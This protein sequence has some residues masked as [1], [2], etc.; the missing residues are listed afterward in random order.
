MRNIRHDRLLCVLQPS[1]IRSFFFRKHD[2][3][4]TDAQTTCQNKGKSENPYP[5]RMLMHYMLHRTGIITH[6]LLIYKCKYTVTGHTS[7]ASELHMFVFL[8]GFSLPRPTSYRL[9]WEL[10]FHPNH[11]ST[12]TLSERKG[13]STAQYKAICAKTMA[14]L[15]QN[16]AQDCTLLDKSYFTHHDFF[17]K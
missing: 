5:K 8:G 4:S 17:W 2:R 11:C 9:L 3:K 10:E 1:T 13:M 6:I 7:R 14:Y 12:Y 16:V 15:S